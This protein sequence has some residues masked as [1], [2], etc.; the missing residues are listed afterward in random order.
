MWYKIFTYSVLIITIN[1]LFL[2]SPKPLT[3]ANN[4]SGE[5]IHISKAGFVLFS[6]SYQY[7]F[8]SSRPSLLL[9]KNFNAVRQNR[10]MYIYAGFLIGKC[11]DWLLKNDSSD[12]VNEYLKKILGQKNINEKLASSPFIKQY[13][14]NQ[15]GNLVM[16]MFPYYLA[17]LFLNFIFLL[18]ALLLFDRLLKLMN[19]KQCIIYFLNLLIVCS[20]VV[21]AFFFSAHEQMFAIVACILLMNIFYSYLTS[22]LSDRKVYLLSFFTGSL[23]LA[24][25]SLVLYVPCLFIANYLLDRKPYFSFQRIFFL[26]L[27]AVIFALPNLVWMWICIIYSGHYLNTEVE[28]FREFIWIA[29]G[30][31]GGPAFLLSLFLH[32]T[33]RFLYPVLIT[34]PVYLIAWR[35]LITLNHKKEIAYPITIFRTF[36]MWMFVLYFIFFWLLGYYNFRLIYTC[37]PIIFAGIAMELHAGLSGGTLKEIKLVKIMKVLSVTWIVWTVVKYGPFPFQ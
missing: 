11:F 27:N 12:F 14:V 2:F 6:D 9:D 32:H 10:P 35:K 3:K 13:K 5:Y 18:A 21:K 30:W 33:S 24:Y 31:K 7:T 22:G 1:G 15:N 34:L 23:C 28:S 37:V 25:G 29:D 4:Y 36:I 19:V 17:Y 20:G 26:F 8:L 16:M